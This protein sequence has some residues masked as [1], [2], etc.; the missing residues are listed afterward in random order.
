MSH[1]SA[2]S[3]TP[4]CRGA[5]SLLPPPLKPGFYQPRML[6]ETS[7][8]RW[9]EWPRRCAQW[10]KLALPGLVFLA[11]C[12]S[13]RPAPEPGPVP[14]ARMV[15]VGLLVDTTEVELGA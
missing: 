9:S 11:S 6:R 8:R 3:S 15:S 7:M 13:L 12:G 1:A 4:A 5:Y 14:G 2:L 10:R